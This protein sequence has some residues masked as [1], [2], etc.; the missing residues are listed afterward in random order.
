MIALRSGALWV[1]QY[2]GVIG[3]APRFS[4]A[5]QIIQNQL[6]ENHYENH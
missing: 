5:C 1:I 4:L 3:I 6:K 2:K